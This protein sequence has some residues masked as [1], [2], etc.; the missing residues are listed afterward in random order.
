MKTTLLIIISLIV[1]SVIGYSVFLKKNP[2]Q[3]RAKKFFTMPI[4]KGM[5]YV[6]DSISERFIAEYAENGKVELDGELEELLHLVVMD[7]EIVEGA[8]PGTEEAFMNESAIILTK[9]A[10]EVSR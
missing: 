7:L 10:N 3:E 9:I 5:D 1:L 6:P 8:K 4:P 2:L